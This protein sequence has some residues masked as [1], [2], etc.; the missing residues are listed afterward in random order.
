[1]RHVLGKDGRPF[2]KDRY[3]SWG[4][5]GISSMEFKPW[6]KGPFKKGRNIGWRCPNC[7]RIFK[8]M[9]I[10]KHRNETCTPINVFRKAS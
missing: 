8:G 7:S 1:M 9:A 5:K 10:K 2:D 4:L 6:K 3:V